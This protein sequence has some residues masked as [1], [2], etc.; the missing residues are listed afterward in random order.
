MQN[1]NSAKKTDCQLQVLCDSGEALT[2][3]DKA[4]N[5]TLR[6]ISAIRRRTYKR[7][8][9]NV[10]GKGSPGIGIDDSWKENNGGI[11]RADTR[12]SPINVGD[13]VQIRSIDEI[14]ATL[15]PTGK[16]E[17]LQF[18]ISMEK[19][20]GREARVFKKVRTIFD[21]RLWKMVKVR[22]AYLLDGIICDGRDVFDGEGC[23]RSCFFFWKD[24]WLL[25]IR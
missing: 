17:G 18:M 11:G 14:K 16:C 20:C 22:N 3:A 21:E 4:R 7:S 10:G 6:L 8:G 24:K 23:D 5:I 9:F 25:K 13:I 2:L 19:Y 15:D 1:K 12:K